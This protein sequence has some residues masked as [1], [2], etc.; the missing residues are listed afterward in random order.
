[1]SHQYDIAIIGASAGGI[2]AVTTILDGLS[3]TLTAPVI[4]V[5]HRLGNVPSSLPSVLQYHSGMRVKEADEKETPSAGT[6]YIAPANYH[7]L[8]EHDRT[9]SLDYSERVQFSRPSIDVSFQSIGDVYG[10]KILAMLLT[11]A[12]QDG[13]EG[14]KYLNDIGATTWVQDP[15]D[16]EVSTM[17]QAAIDLGAACEIMKLDDMILNL[18]NALKA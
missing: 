9:M 10:K 11:G 17:P 3:E 4:V 2:K 16:A 18:N 8:F 13:A 7:L 12:N 6:T 14:M 1:M 15:N 5:M